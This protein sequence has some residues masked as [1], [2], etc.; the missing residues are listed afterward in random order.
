MTFVFLQLGEVLFVDLRLKM[1]VAS[2]EVKESIKSL[3]L[4]QDKQHETTALLVNILT[5]LISIVIIVLYRK[6]L[7]CS[8]VLNALAKN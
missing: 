7:P 3:E 8:M 2:V 5:V 1:M 4:M 6:C